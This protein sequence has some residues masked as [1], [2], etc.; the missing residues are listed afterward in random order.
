MAHLLFITGPILV[1]ICIKLS[2]D[3]NIFLLENYINS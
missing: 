2:D 1:A 3:A